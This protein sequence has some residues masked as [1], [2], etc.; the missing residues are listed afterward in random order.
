MLLWILLGV[1]ASHIRYD[2]SFAAVVH[3]GL[4]D[5]LL[6]VNSAAHI[7][8]RATISDRVKLVISLVW[9]ANI[10]AI[11]LFLWV[12]HRAASK[13]AL[14]VHIV[15]LRGSIW[16]RWSLLLQRSSGCETLNSFITANPILR[17][18]SQLYATPK[19]P[20]GR[21]NLLLLT[22]RQVRLLIN[23]LLHISSFMFWT[24]FVNLI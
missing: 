8:L 20:I 1:D 24:P 15:L 23:L 22:I 19:I 7:A 9:L 14:K 17:V 5:L 6:W 12:L 18:I 21:K 2:T 13:L 16:W 11:Q 3:R 10:F 4:S